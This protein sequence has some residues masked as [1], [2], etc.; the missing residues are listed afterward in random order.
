MFVINLTDI[1][2]VAPFLATPADLQHI[3]AAAEEIYA[4]TGEE[5]LT[6][7]LD[8][9]ETGLTWRSLDGTTVDDAWYC[10][11]LLVVCL[12][13]LRGESAPKIWPLTPD[14]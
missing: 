11:A 13:G 4:T 3:H 10:R 7:V 8:S 5:E 2:P 1:G 9:W 12:R 6:Q 14:H